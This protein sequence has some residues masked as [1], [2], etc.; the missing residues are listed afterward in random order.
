MKNRTTL[1]IVA[2]V[3]GAWVVMPDPCPIV[4][5]DII[6]ALI[7]SATILKLIKQTLM[8]SDA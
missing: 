4:I 1:L 7:G 2:I 8:K 6:A 3:C 5:D